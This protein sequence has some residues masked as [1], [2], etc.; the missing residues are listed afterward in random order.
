MSV[1]VEDWFHDGSVAVDDPAAQR[2]ER[3]IE[4]LR[5]LPPWR[6]RRGMRR[7]ERDVG[8]GVFYLHPRERFV[9]IREAFPEVAA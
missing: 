6:L 5:A 1:D 4:A 2:V 9:S 7:V 3:R 8:A